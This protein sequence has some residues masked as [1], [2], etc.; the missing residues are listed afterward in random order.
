DGKIVAAA[1]GLDE[2]VLLDPVTGK[3]KGKIKHDGVLLGSLA[4]SVDGKILATGGKRGATVA[5]WDVAKKTRTAT[6]TCGK[7]GGVTALAFSGQVLLRSEEAGVIGWDITKKKE[8]FRWRF[9]ANQLA[10]S[11]DGKLVAEEVD[12]FIYDI[13]SGKA[14]AHVDIIPDRVALSV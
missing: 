3:E 13:G 8:T 11:P 4:F 10:V 1:K 7:E 9:V 6:R 2:V 14:R 5:M 12:G